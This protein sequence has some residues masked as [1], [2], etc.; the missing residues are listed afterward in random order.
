MNKFDEYIA[1]AECKYCTRL[2]MI[3]K[4]LEK[5]G[6]ETFNAGVNCWKIIET[7]ASISVLPLQPDLASFSAWKLFSHNFFFSK[8]KKKK[9]KNGKYNNNQRIKIFIRRFPET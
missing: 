3:R 6:F 5:N 4:E 1:F 8:N 9:I 2:K 7:A